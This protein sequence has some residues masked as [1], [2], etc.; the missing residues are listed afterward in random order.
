MVERHTYFEGTEF[1]GTVGRTVEES[2][3]AWPM[4]RSSPS[5]APN[6]VVLVLDDVGFGQLGCFGGLGGRIRTPNIDRLAAGGLRYNNFHV[7][8]MCSPTRASLLTGR[9]HHTVGVGLIMEVLSGYP[10]YN[11]QIPKETAM[12][13]AVL[14]EHGYATWAVGKWHLTPTKEINPLGPMDRWPLRQGFDRYYG[15]LT[16]Q[17]DQYRPS[18]WEDNHHVGFPND[19]GEPY[20]FTEDIVDHSIRWLSERQAVAPDRPFFHYLSPGAMHQPHQV[21]EEWVAPYA[22]AFSDGWDVIRE[23]TLARQKEL[24]VVPAETELPPPNPGVLEWSTLTSRERRLVERQMEVFAGFMEHTDHHVGRFIEAL[25]KHGVLDNTVFLV[26]SDNGASAEGTQ[27]GIRHQIS[28]FNGE[29]ETLEEK[30]DAI[31]G[32]AGPDN[33]TNYAVGWAMAGNTPNRWYK[34]MTHEG[35]TRSPLIVHWPA[36]ISDA[37]GVRNQFHHVTD[38]FPT[39]LQAVGVDMPERVRGYEQKP[40]EGVSLAYTFDAPSAPT[41]KERQYFEMLGHRAIW[42]DGWKA[43]TAHMSREAQLLFMGGVTQEPSDGRFDTEKWELYHLDQDFS[44]ANDLAEEHPEL[45]KRLE[46][47]WWEEA[48]RFDVLPLDDR[49]LGRYREN[50]ESSVGDRDE[51]VYYEPLALTTNGSPNLKGVSHTI[52]AQV[53]VGPEGAD[54]VIVSDGGPTGGYALGFAD[55]RVTY[56]SNFLG[57][58]VRIV[59]LPTPVSEGSLSITMRFVARQDPNPRAGAGT[60]HLSVDGGESAVLEVART[61]PT[62]YDLTGEGLRIGRDLNGVGPVFSRPALLTPQLVRVRIRREGAPSVHADLES[63]SAL[64]EQ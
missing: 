56:V 39:L 55:G 61:N 20:H 10:G 5:G 62:R 54:G 53:V 36:G 60:V 7:A 27:L 23:E 38:L 14:S 59:Q 48:E 29:Q 57:R 44:E 58:D 21:P 6:V 45:V 9:N 46:S 63:R 37:G 26:M 51:Y 40:L 1:P 12:L 3:P 11:G 32:W 52:D 43:V 22:G 64:V 19:N 30:L 16:A 34:R 49:Y 18:L 35:G 17:S 50:R 15:F 41:T 33:C 13:P 31:D 2:Q 28:Y 4:P 42:A 47:I 8:P 25:E 24:G